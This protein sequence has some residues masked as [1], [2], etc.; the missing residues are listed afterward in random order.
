MGL[1][2]GLSTALSGL[3]TNQKGL[4]VIS[5]NIVNVNTKGY[6]R[7][8]MTPES[9]TVAGMGAGVQTGAIVRNVD[10]GL[11]KDIRR[12]TSTQG[13]LDTLHD[14]YPR[15]ED[16]FGQ[17]GDNNSIAHQVET[18]QSSFDALGV[19]INT[20]ALQT[21]VITTSL[22]TANKFSQM[23]DNIQNLRLEA[24]RGIQD[25][26]GLINE[27]IS[28]IFDLNQ[29]IVRGGAIGADIGDL[30]D[31][32]DNALTALAQYMD[33]QYFERGD[34]SVGV[35]TKTGKTLVDKGAATMTHVSTTVTD[36]WMT[37]AGGNFNSITLSTTS[38]PNID[39]SAD[40]K[41]G[42]IRAL[43]DLRDS[44]LPNLQSQV[45]ELANKLKDTVNLAHNRGTTYPTARSQ[46]TGTHQL[47]D[48]N[49]PSINGGLI[50]AAITPN[51]QT[52]WLS[53]SNDVAITL[54]DPNGNE[55][56]STTLK[57]IMGSTSYNDA[58]G[59]ATSLDISSSATTPGVKI[60]DVAAKIQNWMRAQNYQNNALSNATASI[61]NGT[62]ALNTGNTSVT[63]DFRDQASST[64]GST[65]TDATI[66]FDV[67]GDGSADQQVQ[68]FSNFFGLNDLFTEVSPRSISDSTI[69]DQATT[70][71]STRTFRLLDPSGQIGNTVTVLAGSSLSSIADAINKQT[72]T[73]ESAVLSS[74]SMTMVGNS[75]L[76]IAD[77]NGN[78]TGFPITLAAGTTTDLNV[79]AQQINNVGGSVLAKVVQNGPS[80]Y[81]LRVW[82]SRGVELTVSASGGTVGGAT[83]DSYLG[84]R[85]ANLVQ[86]S[87]IPDGSGYR[88]RIRQTNDQEL[89]IGATPDSQTPPGS[90]VTDLGLHAAATRMAS[91]LSVRT[92]I[93]GSPSLVSRGATQYN[94]DLDKYYLSEGDNTTTLA[95]SQAMANKQSMASAGNIYAGSYNFSEYA[96]ASIS[97][98]S[99]GAAHAD[100]QRS[101][102]T[103][104]GQA[105]NNQYTSMS[106]V[107]LDE[108]VANMINFQQAYSASA[109][110]ISTLQQMLDTLVNIIR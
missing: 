12:Q 40:I 81:Q 13:S 23:T 31:K 53:G 89:F 6:V 19:Q 45:D 80:S 94:A 21:A 43:L 46:M 93:Q 10:E 88:L 101:Y 32:R 1:T 107:N 3:L 73:N 17:V 85:K 28:N 63:L 78:I 96:A 109:K 8:V 99:T 75:T 56:V 4:D 42:K 11:M 61:T 84:M 39:I 66:N 25:T 104:L 18:L 29:K 79:I 57:T 77:S 90:I 102:Q 7:K 44:V 69:L 95:I 24:D 55:I 110:V 105:L 68:G 35:Y 51:S 30:K 52:M 58:A 67:D 48:P 59:A 87:V 74:H 20:S 5:Q 108:E 106:G 98:V 83:L 54:F 15:I 36:S 62:F 103:T 71:N 26:V 82:D 64:K 72:Q 9:V 70:L 60:T 27:Q 65:A 38:E 47:I 14:Y 37:A 92:D 76:S 33:I 41:D 50:P 100:E 2:L 86:A 49:N 34:G 22:D 16:L 91:G 97:V